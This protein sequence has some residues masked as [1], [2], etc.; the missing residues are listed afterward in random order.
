MAVGYGQGQ[1]LQILD[2]ATPTFNFADSPIA[3]LRVM[4]AYGWEEPLWRA[5]PPQMGFSVNNQAVLRPDRRSGV[6]Y[7]GTH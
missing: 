2:L 1:Q 5:T 6:S 7:P 4:G 3:F